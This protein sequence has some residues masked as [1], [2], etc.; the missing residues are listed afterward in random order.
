MAHVRARNNG[1]FTGYFE[2]GD[3]V[4]SAG[5]FDT[6]EEA[7]VRALDAQKTGLAPL[8]RVTTPSHPLRQTYR[9]YAERWM[10]DNPG[11]SERTL[12]GYR[13]NM[14]NHVFPIIGNIKV[15]DITRATIVGMLDKLEALGISAGVRA[16]CKAAVG[17]SFKPLVEQDLLPVS[18]THGVKVL[19]PPP[20]D[21]DLVEP[22]DF[23]QIM[24]HLP[25]EGARLFATFLI[26]TGAR[27]GEAAEIRVTDINPRKRQVYIRRRVVEMSGFAKDGSRF[28]VVDGTK[29]GEQF[30]RKIRIPV[31]VSVDLVRWIEDHDMGEDDLL[32]PKHLITPGAHHDT[33]I[34]HPGRTFQKDGKAYRHGTAHGYTGGKCRCD[35]CRAALRRYRRELRRRQRIEAAQQRS[36]ASQPS[37]R[38]SAKDHGRTT[39]NYTGHLPN[40]KWRLV[41]RAAVKA[42]GLGWYPRT[43]DLRH[44]CATHLVAR[45]VSLTEVQ[46]MLGH[47]SID[48][49]MRY[50][51]EVEWMTSKAAEMT[52]EFLG[53]AGAS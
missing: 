11:V 31:A 53:G 13:G 49:T 42:S 20:P 36:G 50:Q 41:W 7:Y 28:H 17:S 22:E 44:A 51:H 32:F 47:Q 33:S 3:R 6:Y 52:E 45:G 16:Q 15:A 24:A 10:Q 43:H 18:P 2:I 9:V 1:R 29:P 21:F 23:Q 26:T 5:T 46:R 34:V 4:R 30:G 40:D 14:T 37:S 12:R 8:A 19:L 48:T 39:A 35:N 38:P 25:T 27:F